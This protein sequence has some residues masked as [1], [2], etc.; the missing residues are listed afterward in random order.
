MMM[1]LFSNSEIFLDWMKTEFITPYS[2]SNLENHHITGSLIVGIL[3]LWVFSTLSVCFFKTA[4]KIA[5][6]KQK[7]R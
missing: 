5:D 6:E 7:K 1:S 4:Q 3:L 2:F